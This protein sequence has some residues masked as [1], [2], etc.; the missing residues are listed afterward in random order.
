[1]P[2]LMGRPSAARLI[3]GLVILIV[4]AQAKPADVTDCGPNGS[5]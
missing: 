1:V 5:G 4:G 3:R 2:C